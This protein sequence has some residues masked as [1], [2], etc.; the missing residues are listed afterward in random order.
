[1]LLQLSY[2]VHFLIL[3]RLGSNSGVADEVIAD[4]VTKPETVTLG[5]LFSYIKQ[6]TAKVQ[7]LLC[8]S[9]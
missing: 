9:I 6:E 7:C 1:M 2:N 4:V 3:N 8:L 5:E